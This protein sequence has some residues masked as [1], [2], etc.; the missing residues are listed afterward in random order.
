MENIV[1]TGDM[2]ACDF[3]DKG[4]GV[5]EFTCE[6]QG[7]KDGEFIKKSDVPVRDI[8][9]QGEY[10]PGYIKTGQ[11][12]RHTDRVFEISLEGG[13]CGFGKSGWGGILTC[14]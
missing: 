4:H 13:E 5:H 1:D 2:L 6:I 3:E 8:D 11:K 9:I 10:T 14:R 7:E 12:T